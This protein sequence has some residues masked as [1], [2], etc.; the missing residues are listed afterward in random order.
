MNK[1]LIIRVS[2]WSMP[3]LKPWN[4]K[5]SRKPIVLT[6]VDLV[7]TM[8]CDYYNISL[9]LIMSKKRNREIVFARQVASYLLYKYVLRSLKAVSDVFDQDHTTVIHSLKSVNDIMETDTLTMVDI[10][11]LEYKILSEGDGLESVKDVA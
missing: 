7:L 1:N 10:E 9:I 11:H 5:I 3:G 4:G 2:Y 8:V 6:S